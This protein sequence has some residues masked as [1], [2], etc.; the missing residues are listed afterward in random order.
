MADN[1]PTTWMSLPN[2]IPGSSA[3]PQYA[4]DIQSCFT[5]VDQH[6]HSA[7]SG[8]QIQ[9]NG[10]NING[11]LSFQSNNAYALRTVRFTPQGS[12]IP[13]SGLDVGCLYVA[14]NELYYNDVSGGHQVAIT[15]NGNVNAT[16]SGIS[17]GAASAA[18]V[19]GVLVVKSSST[20]GANVEMQSAVLTNNGNLTNTLTL[21][22]PTLSSS[23]AQTF[24]ITP[25]VTSFMTMDSSGN[26][27]VGTAL[28]GALTT[29]NLSASAGIIGTQLSASAGI[30][31]TQIASTTIAG[32]NL[33]NN[34][35][36]GTQMSLTLAL[37]G[38]LTV[39]TTLGVTGNATIASGKNVIASAVNAAAGLN[40]VRAA[41][42]SGGTLQ[43]GEGAT[44][45]NGSTGNYQIIWTH[46]FSDVPVMT[47][48]TAPGSIQSSVIEIQSIA[49]DQAFVNISI[50]GVATNEPFHIIVIGQR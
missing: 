40:I 9:P 20:S 42:T 11:D 1:N 23:L 45:V 24:P 28:L 38:S 35:L 34:T 31:G 48:T 7:G 33:I 15:L 8:Q 41:F 14:G 6:N 5:I 39:A 37:A 36:T 29:S 27:G 30:V 16:S 2:P 32:S 10:L 4:L 43:Y 25:A 12:A 21:Q 50:G 13:N 47:C 49:V 22:A 46:A 19:G 18:F 44:C 26:M 17:S 3:G